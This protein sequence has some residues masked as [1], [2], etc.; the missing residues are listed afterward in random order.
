MICLMNTLQCYN[1]KP[2]AGQKILQVALIVK[3]PNNSN[4][5]FREKNGHSFII[6]KPHRTSHN[7]KES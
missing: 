6:Q 4:I 7:F 2:Y 5:S 3:I 1:Y